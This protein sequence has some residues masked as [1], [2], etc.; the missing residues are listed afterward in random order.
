LFE[1]RCRRSA[2]AL[3]KFVYLPVCEER[4]GRVVKELTRE[5]LTK[6]GYYVRIL[7][8]ATVA[9]LALF[10]SSAVVPDHERPSFMQM[11]HPSRFY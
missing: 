5:L 3:G 6:H 8:P 1:A 10:I 2:Q 9:L 4:G 11:P 7:L